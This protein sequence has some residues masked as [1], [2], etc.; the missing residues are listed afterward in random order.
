MHNLHQKFRNIFK[1]SQNWSQDEVTIIQR[2]ENYRHCE[3]T[4]QSMQWYYSYP[5]LV[6]SQEKH[7]K[8]DHRFT[9]P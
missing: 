5:H 1:K 9:K 8:I 7:S 6:C 3:H 4:N 2:F